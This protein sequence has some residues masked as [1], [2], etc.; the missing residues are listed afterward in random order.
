MLVLNRSLLLSPDGILLYSASHNA[1]VR[2][3]K[4]HVAVL[5]KSGIGRADGWYAAWY[6]LYAARVEITLQDMAKA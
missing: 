3:S 4:K 5:V 6:S 2:Y 1:S